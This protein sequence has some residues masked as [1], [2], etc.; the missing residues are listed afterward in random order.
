MNKI[1]TLLFSMCVCA[2]IAQPNVTDSRGR[3]QGEWGKKYPGTSIFMYKGQFLNDKPVGKFV[4]KYESSKTKAVIKHIE[5]S[6]RSVAYFY[7]EN[8]KMMSH[9]IYRNM[10]KDSVWI[11][12]TT[13]SQLSVV[14]N[15]KDGELN[16]KRTTYFLPE[17]LSDKSQIPS[18]VE[19]Y[20][21][22]ILHGEI[23]EYF[24]STKVKKR[25]Q[26]LNG[27]KNGLWEDFHPGGKKMTVLRY[28]N[29]TKHG[30]AF[31]YDS[32]GVEESK[33]YYYYGRILTGEKL[34]EKM[35]YLKAK[36]ISP[37]G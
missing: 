4:Y 30:W 2:L 25:G 15:F 12:F 21:N 7:H 16:G 9:G 11:N 31:T 27:K 17:T 1:L 3:K 24:L 8:G 36:G 29:G 28:K 20:L 6:T 32:K 5:N 22:G 13:L 18:R 19:H 35:Q 14:E 37:N 34:K 10:K 23:R 26:Y 33:N